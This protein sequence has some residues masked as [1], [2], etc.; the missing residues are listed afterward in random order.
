MALGAWLQLDALQRDT[1][2]SLHDLDEFDA[3]TALRHVHEI[4]LGSHKLFVALPPA[5]RKH[6]AFTKFLRHG[7]TVTRSDT[8]Y[9]LHK[10]EHRVED[11][12]VMV[13][14]SAAR[15]VHTNSSLHAAS[16]KIRVGGKSVRALFDTGAS[17]SC[18]HVEAVQQMG[19]HITRQQVLP[20]VGIGGEASVIG[21]VDAHVKV[22]ASQI[23]QRFVVLDAPISG[24]DVLL[25]QDYLAL[26]QASI[27]FTATHCHL[28]LQSDRGN[29]S[30]SRALSTSVLMHM[31]HS[32]QLFMQGS[33]PT[34]HPAV[35]LS[36]GDEVT[37][38]KDFKHLQHDINAGNQV[39]YRIALH[40]QTTQDGN[41][42]PT[43]VQTVIDK[44]SIEGG[45]LCGDIPLGA[46]AK[47]FEM[48]IDLL[49]NARPVQIKQYRLTPKEEEALLTKAEEFIKRGWIE[50]STSSWNSAVL[51]VPK[52]N[53]SL[54]FCVDFRF[55]NERTI[56]DK[57]NIPVIQQLLDKMK[58]AQVF[59]AL[60]LCSGFYQI[61][62]APDSRAYTAFST[63][64]GL[65]QWCV[66]PMGLSNSP[67]VFQRAMNE[68]LKQHILK[69]Y[70]LVYLD[71][72]LI[73]SS[74]PEEHAKHL[75]AVLTSLQQHEL[76][77]Q[78]P[79]CDFALSEL[80]YLGHLVNGQ[81]IKPDPKKVAAL[82]DWKPPLDD[83]AEL[84][85]AD[86][87]N[88]R[89]NALKKQIAHATRRFLGFMQYF[90]RFI[91]RFSYLAACLY[92]CTRDEPA[93]W[94]DECTIAWDQLRACLRA[95]TLLYHPDPT[96]AYH[97]YFDA[98]I[99]GV[100]G[101]LGQEF[102]GELHPVAF[103][104]RR[105]QPAETR[106]STTEQEMLAMVHCFKTWRCYLEG[107]VVFAHTDHEPLTWLAGQKSMNRRQAHWMEF[108]GRFDFTL[109]YI[110]G[111]RN[112]VADALSRKLAFS[113]NAPMP[114]PGEDW[115]H[116]PEKVM[117]TS[118]C[119]A[120][121]AEPRTGHSVRQGR[122]DP[123]QSTSRCIF[124]LGAFPTF[125]ARVGCAPHSL[126][127]DPL[128]HCRGG[129]LPYR[130]SLSDSV[131]VA[132]GS[133][134]VGLVLA[135]R[136]AGVNLGGHTRRRAGLGSGGEEHRDA[137]A[138]DKSGEQP[139][140]SRRSVAVEPDSSQVAPGI[141]H[142]I[143]YHIISY[144]IISYHIIS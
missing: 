110:K 35:E 33:F 90:G 44:H 133:V 43:V 84:Q 14:S 87:S 97:V 134:R 3:H 92:D 64:L 69:G 54:R 60:D 36:E 100:G 7:E 91:P 65:Y 29:V 2:L 31:V 49:P 25:G 93:A 47:G 140:P 104:A 144:H 5:M 124:T 119:C 102:E 70:C 80:R 115:P 73:M 28:D 51:F 24:Y 117:L 10:R 45:T 23:L 76:F 55:L 1:V 40:A 71:D 8:A 98:S 127:H 109:L 20:L 89:R 77:C 39:A 63:P 32:P 101:M 74:S 75:D 42:V 56:K 37:S 22:G 125:R 41:K 78:L 95:T 67:A 121:R 116:S 130:P 11:S 113:D 52:P 53:G 129:M 17:C 9:S 61:P 27:R 12:T 122:V 120:R 30:L 62:L 96:V 126:P 107:A 118:L 88:A 19:L 108:L 26:T 94:T 46:H 86:T 111:D 34:L 128:R 16:F 123:F 142:I 58:G 99:R 106:Y 59:S 68:V 85:H 21:H 81:G 13:F 83:V 72:V 18:I 50:P 137:T 143:S 139:I 103:C 136:R 131:S 48:Q 6:P 38:L 132:P 105:M 4:N 82:D 112:V 114:L 66:M 79:K 135:A 138:R 141:Y 15:E 57:G